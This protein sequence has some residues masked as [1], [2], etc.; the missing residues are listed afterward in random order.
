MAWVL[1]GSLLCACTTERTG[2]C[3]PCPSAPACNSAT[4][5]ILAA[6]ALPL[7]L[8]K[9]AAGQD[10]QLVLEVSILANGEIRADGNAVADTRALGELAKAAVAKNRDTRVV[11]RADKDAKHGRVI[12]V[13]DALKQAGITKIAFG[14]EPTP[15]V[16]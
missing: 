5:P 16:P 3:P 8:P 14:V 13:L 7:D 4:S 9:S 1:F 10:E 15:A 6:S 2:S 12:A 11:I